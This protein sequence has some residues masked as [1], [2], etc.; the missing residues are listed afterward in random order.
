MFAIGLSLG[1]HQLTNVIGHAG[2]HCEFTAAFVIECP[3]NLDQCVKNIGDSAVAD[4][5]LGFKMNKLMITNKQVMSPY[6]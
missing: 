1:A 5:A 3:F 4:Y 2:L 6:V